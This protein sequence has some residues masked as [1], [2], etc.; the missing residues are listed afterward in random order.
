MIKNKIPLHVFAGINFMLLSLIPLLVFLNF[1]NRSP[2]LLFEF[3]IDSLEI[4]LPFI[5]FLYMVLN[6]WGYLLGR[7][8]SRYFSNLLLFFFALLIC[9]LIFDLRDRIL[10]GGNMRLQFE[11]IGSLI[12]MVCVFL[13]I[14]L[15]IHNDRVISGMQKSANKE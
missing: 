6:G 11:S 14:T 5:T 15:Y 3:S 2:E 4:Y 7:P 12:S 1:V 9:V 13:G 10:S 8:K